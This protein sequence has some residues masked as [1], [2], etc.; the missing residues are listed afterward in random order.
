MA[1]R[2]SLIDTWLIAKS[3]FLAPGAMIWSKLATV[4]FTWSLSKPSWSATAYAT[5][6]SKPL[7]LV[8]SLSTTHGS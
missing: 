5:A 3:N 7:P 8:G 4:H 6:D 2:S 1:L